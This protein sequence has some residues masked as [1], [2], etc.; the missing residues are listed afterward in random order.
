[1]SANSF[2]GCH[3]PRTIKICTTSIAENAK[4]AWLRETAAVYGIEPDL[5]CIKAD[6]TTHCMMAMNSDNAAD[7]V[8]VPPDL[9]TLARR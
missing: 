4:C 3:P 7:V 1:M 5:D 6:N 9:T 2:S 8:M